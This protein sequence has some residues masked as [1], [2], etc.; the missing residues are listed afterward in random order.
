MFSKK[1]KPLSEYSSWELIGYRFR[2][3]KLAMLGVFMFVLIVAVTIGITKHKLDNIV[4]YTYYSAYSALRT[5]TS[6]ML[7]D[8][9]P[10]DE[11]YQAKVENSPKATPFFSIKELKIPLSFPLAP[12]AKLSFF[13]KSSTSKSLKQS[14]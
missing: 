7:V 12:L 13:S 4:T 11:R 9:D 14:S 6:Q 8:Y 5:A 3:N 2:K 1:K 10:N